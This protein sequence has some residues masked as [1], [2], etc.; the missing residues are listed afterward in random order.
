MSDE[1]KKKKSKKWI[2][3]AL[4]I[5]LIVMGILTFFSNTIMNMTLTQVSTQQI[6]GGTLTSISRTSGLLR[7]NTE[8]Q[9][10]S[11]GEIK[12]EEVPVYPY[13]EV[14]EGDVLAVLEIPEKKE[15][16]EDKKK[17]LEDLKKKMGYDERTP[18]R[19]VDHYADEMQIVDYEK[20]VTQATKNLEAAKNKEAA[21]AK[22][23]TEI[24]TIEDAIVQLNKEAADLENQKAEY[25]QRRDE[26]YEKF[27]TAKESLALAQENLAAQITDPADPNFDQAALDAANQA[28]ADAE[29][30]VQTHQDSYNGFNANIKTVSDKMIDN[31]TAKAAKDAELQEKQTDLAEFEQLSSVEDAERALK[32][33]KHNLQQAKQ[34]LSDAR[35]NEGIDKDKAADDKAL[36]LKQLEDLEKEVEELEKYYEITEIKAPISGTLI[37]I[38][39]ERKGT[40][41]KDDVLF[42]IADMESGF[43]IECPVTKTEAQSLY[44]GMEV[45]T[46]ISESSRIESIRPDPQNPSDS[47][48]IKVEIENSG[49]YMVPGAMTVDC[50]LS[51]FN[52]SYES[53]VPKGAVQTDSEGTFIYVLVTKNSPLGE[54]Y[55]ARK[56]EVKI[57]AEDATTYAI[58]GSGISYA[59]CIVRTEKPIKNGEQV[60]LAEGEAI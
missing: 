20:A 51:T 1:I 59:Y 22:T 49:W 55:I 45:R 8:L 17:Q 18:N 16:L 9:V 15:D 25:E 54:R 37:T 2:I 12:I 14:A 4:I 26:A 31:E 33:A 42:V 3:K 11:P 57:L 28:V 47:C 46:D 48:I 39:A 24:K 38:N 40:Y 32:D 60:R 58:Q 21:I 30:E 36:E 43:Y 6:Y 5:F 29:K 50:T 35:T 10:K 44:P 56:V 7:A 13:Q 19:P 53:V 52:K 41:A 34:T 27:E 23:K